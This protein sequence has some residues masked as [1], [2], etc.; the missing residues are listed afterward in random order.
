MSANR[1]LHWRA[2]DETSVEVH[3][4][5]E[6]RLRVKFEFDAGGDIVR[7]SSTAR[8]LK[9][10]GHWVATPWVGEFSDCRELG[11]MRMPTVAAVSWELPEGRYRYWQA[12]I[13]AARALSSPF[14]LGR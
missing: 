1:E 7:A 6:P 13:V 11:G 4:E 14:C 9:R 5:P 10:R 3:L 2:I 12:R 8:Q